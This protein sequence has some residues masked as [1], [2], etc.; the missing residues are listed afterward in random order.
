MGF[1]KV[2]KSK[3]YFK[4]FQVKF[5][6]RREGK[7]DYY[8]R[9]RLVAQD[10]NKYNAPK[11]RLIVRITNKDVVAQIAY[12]TLDGDI[13]LAAAYGHELSNYGIPVGHTNYASVYAVGLLVARRHLAKLGL[14]K[15]FVG[16]TANVA[17]E[18]RVEASG[19][20][21][22]PFH[23]IF[24]AGLARTSTGARIF[25]GLKGAVD[26]GLDIPY[27]V[28]RFTGYKKSD[29]GKGGALNAEV[30]RKYILGGHVAAYLTKLQEK[31]E[32]KY[33]VQFSQYIKHGVTGAKLESLYVEAHKKIRANPSYTKK[34][35]FKG[36]KKSFKK[37]KR[38]YAE[39][40]S[41]AASKKK[42]LGLDKY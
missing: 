15:D 5:R 19:E 4:R 21:R 37:I 39:R 24:D 3:S 30:F 40:K 18:F 31:D 26:G 7:T 12:A 42:E 10:K 36:E 6:R 33:K 32:A 20:G 8:A 11:Y 2:I 9:K 17:D 23:A 41:H 25:A 29:E 38:T 14:D 22:R 13:I 35:G 34:A 27:S 16:N 1:V 28:S